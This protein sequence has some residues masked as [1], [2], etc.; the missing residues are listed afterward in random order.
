MIPG[1]HL[2]RISLDDESTTAGIPSLPRQ[3]MTHGGRHW[4][5]DLASDPGLGSKLQR[6]VED[7]PDAIDVPVKAGDLVI[8][9]ARLYHAAYE[10]KSDERRTCITMWWLNWDRCGPAFRAHSSHGPM[11]T[12]GTDFQQSFVEFSCLFF[13]F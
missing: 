2:H 10:N 9:D 8:G 5:D 12:T 4:K 11:P 7:R 13:A 3:E 1:S 6:A